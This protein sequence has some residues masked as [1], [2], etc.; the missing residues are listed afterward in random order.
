[1]VHK[2]W[3][4]IIFVRISNPESALSASNKVR[5]EYWAFWVQCIWTLHYRQFCRVVLQDL[6]FVSSRSKDFAPGVEISRVM[7]VAS[8]LYMT[9]ASLL[10]Y[11]GAY[12]GSSDREHLEPWE[13]ISISGNY[14]EYYGPIVLTTTL[15][16][17]K[18]LPV[19]C[20]RS[21]VAWGT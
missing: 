16:S 15:C 14:E 21:E 1:M 9:N 7:G 8:G 13:F 20:S 5:S 10:R 19:R 2:V 17:Q 11:P 3:C 4:Q 12:S 6:R 18:I